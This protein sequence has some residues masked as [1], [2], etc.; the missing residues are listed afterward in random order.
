MIQ[1]EELKRNVV[2]GVPGTHRVRYWQWMAERYEFG[3]INYEELKK[4]H[5]AYEKQISMDMGD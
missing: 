5:C 3:D 4:K 1:D 2:E